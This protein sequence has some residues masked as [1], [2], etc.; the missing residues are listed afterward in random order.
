MNSLCAVHFALLVPPKLRS[1]LYTFQ[2]FLHS[3]DAFTC[4]PCTY[5]C[6][7]IPLHIWSPSLD[8]ICPMTY[9]WSLS[10]SK[11]NSDCMDTTIEFF[12]QHF[13][14]GQ[15]CQRQAGHIVTFLKEPAGKGHGY[16]W[17]DIQRR[18]ADV[19][20]L[21]CTVMQMTYIVFSVNLILVNFS[22]TSLKV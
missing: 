14:E 12:C 3:Q 21:V 2:M 4:L 5:Q 22:V 19:S 17:S 18:Y 15:H 16:N 9:F 10:I 6:W 1:F 8:T 7:G 11:G 20:H 13:P